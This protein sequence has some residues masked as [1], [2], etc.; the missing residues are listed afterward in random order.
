MLRM[1]YAWID[2]DKPVASAVV[3]A[4]VAGFS[5]VEMAVVLCIMGVIASS[6]LMLSNAKQEQNNADVTKTRIEL[7][8]N[9]L[10]RQGELG[11]YL[12]CPAPLSVLESAATFGVASDCN[13]AVVAGV[14]EVGVSPNAVRIGAVPVRSLNLPTNVAYDGWGNRFTYM[15]VTDIAKVSA[16]ALASYATT[17]TNNV[18]QVLDASGNQTLEAVNNAVVAFA[19]ISHGKDGRGAYNRKGAVLSACN[20]TAKDGENCDGDAVVRDMR[21]MDSTTLANNYFDYVRWLPIYLWQ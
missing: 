3:N 4:A 18:I 2:N 17:A 7:I 12:T 5:L 16:T 9:A 13:A 20:A 19:V 1:L 10:K 11:G 21:I 15:V 8:V 6:A 14:T